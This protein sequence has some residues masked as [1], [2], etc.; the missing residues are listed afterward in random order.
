VWCS[1]I[2]RR[3]RVSGDAEIERRDVAA[4]RGCGELKKREIKAQ[5]QKIDEGR[6]AEV[7]GAGVRENNVG[8]GVVEAKSYTSQC[9]VEAGAG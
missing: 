6:V 2:R 4:N 8:D 3:E 1:C 5:T 9:A 7:R